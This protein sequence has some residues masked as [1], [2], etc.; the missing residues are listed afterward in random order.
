[1]Y[2]EAEPSVFTTIYAYK[3]AIAY[4]SKDSDTLPGTTG[5]SDA[6]VKNKFNICE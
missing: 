3:P 5:T 2:S 6:M 1:M 4:S